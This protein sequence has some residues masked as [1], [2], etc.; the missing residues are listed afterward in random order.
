MDVPQLR[1]LSI[2]IFMVLGIIASLLVIVATIVVLTKVTSILR[3]VQETVATIKGTSRLIS[4]VVAKPT[5]KAASFAIGVQRAL[6][7]ISGL[8]RRKERGKKN[9]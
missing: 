2:V 4:E 6:S 1:D 3:D 5:I 7:V 9:G 8:R